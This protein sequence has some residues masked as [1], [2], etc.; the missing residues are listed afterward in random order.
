M[1]LAGLRRSYAFQEGP[2]LIPEAWNSFVQTLPLPGQIGSTTYGVICGADMQAGSF[3]YMCAVEVEDFAGLDPASGRMKV[4]A[5]KYAVFVHHGPLA[6][7]RETIEVSHH[8]LDAN[9]VWVDGHTPT[10]ERYGPDFDAATGAD[11]EIWLPVVA[12]S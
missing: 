8:W 1:L 6:A 12:A 5:A 3:E 9:G 11:T 4:P 2:V 10:F 7:I